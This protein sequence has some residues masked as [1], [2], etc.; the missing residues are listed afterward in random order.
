MAS[1]LP[2]TLVLALFFPGL[3]TLGAAWIAAIAGLIFLDSFLAAPRRAQTLQTIAPKL[4]YIG[5]TEDVT[6]SYENKSGR[7]LSLPEFRLTANKRLSASPEIFE[8]KSSPSGTAATFSITSKRRGEGNLERLWVRW[9]GPFGLIWKQNVEPLN[10]RIP[11]I[12]NIRSV[13]ETALEIFSRDA[14]FGHKIQQE[15][16]EG[17]EFDALK[18]FQTGMDRRAID[19][20]HSARHRKLL[21]KEF[22]TERN[23]NVVFAF[24]SGHLMCEPV[25]GV[26]KLDRALNASLIMSYVCLRIGDRV[27]YYAFDERPY[28]YTQPVG[29]VRSFGHIQNLTANIDYSLAETNFTL[30]LSQLSQ[31]LKRRSLI[32]VFTDFVDSTNAE[33]MVENISRLIRRHVVVFVAYRDETLEDMIQKSPETTEDISRAVI[34]DSLRRERDI[35]V[36]RLIRLGVHVVDT[37]VESL[38]INVLNKFLDLKRRELI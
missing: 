24:D 32:V 14:S 26:T 9:Q 1:G 16:G 28:F 35:V 15:R 38:N 29:G 25:R 30:G 8:A 18:E 6:F 17:T 34:S 22:R 7:A 3:W 13:K 2:V 19:W 12:S 5:E 23:H 20:K 11:I 31:N 27:G 37:D 36:A 4:L 33:L 21:A 10:I